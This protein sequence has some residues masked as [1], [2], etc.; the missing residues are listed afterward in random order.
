MSWQ[1]NVTPVKLALCFATIVFFFSPFVTTAASGAD[2]TYMQ[3]S[4]PGWTN[5]A[6]IA[7]NN[8]GTVAGYGSPP[9]P[10]GTMSFI[11]SGGINGTYTPLILPV[12]AA[13]GTLVQSEL[14]TYFSMPWVSS[15]PAMRFTREVVTPR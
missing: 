1:R 4:L 15:S 11:Y 12:Q 13:Q 8:S 7:I 6:G 10:Y 14:S 2:Y 3:L 5:T 9:E